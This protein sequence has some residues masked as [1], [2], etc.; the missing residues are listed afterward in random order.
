MLSLLLLLE[1]ARLHFN[2]LQFVALFC[3]VDLMDQIGR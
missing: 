3:Y 1:S 2:Y